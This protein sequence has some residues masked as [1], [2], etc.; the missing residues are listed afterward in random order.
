VGGSLTLV[1]RGEARALLKADY[2]SMIE[3]GYFEGAVE[4]FGELMSL[5]GRLVARMNASA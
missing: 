1:P 4:N 5:S 2:L 3:A